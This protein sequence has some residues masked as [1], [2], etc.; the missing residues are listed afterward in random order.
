MN[1][2]QLGLDALL[3]LL[4]PCA[5]DVDVPQPHELTLYALSR[6]LITSSQRVIRHGHFPVQAT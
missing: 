4:L 1:S 5:D 3:P 2:L 6:L